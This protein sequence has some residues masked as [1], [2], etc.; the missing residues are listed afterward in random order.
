MCGI[1]GEFNF[2]GEAINRDAF[3]ARRD[4]LAHRG[5]DAAKSWFS[6][7]G[8]L[9]LGQRRLSIIDLDPR[10]N[11]PMTNEDNTVHVVVNGE[12]Y[13]F[14]VLK[15]ELESMGHLFSTTSDSEVVV[16]GWEEWGKE[17]P[18]RLEGMFALAV[19][20]K[21][22][23]FLCR[24]RFGIKPLYYFLVP[25]K[26]I[27]SSE[28]KSIIS[29]PGFYRKIDSSSFLDFFV[30]RYIPSPKTI[31]QNVSKLP[32][33]FAAEIN[34]Q[35]HFSAWEYWKPVLSER[36]VSLD[37]AAAEALYLFEN[38]MKSHLMSDVPVGTFLSGGYDSSS[39]VVMQHRLNAL[40]ITFSMG[41]EGWNKSEHLFA[42]IVA[43]R[44]NTKHYSEIVKNNDLEIIDEL[45]FYYD[46]PN[47]DISTLPT[48]MVSRLASSKVK[49]VLSGEGA[50]EIFAGYSWHHLL[51]DEFIRKTRGEKIT[52]LH[53]Y[54]QAMAMGLFDREKLQELAG[55]EISTFI[56]DDPFW[57]YKQ[58]FKLDVHPLKACQFLDI[59]TFMAELVLQKVDRA[60]MAHSLEARV[61]FL[62]RKLVEFMLSLHPDAY[63]SLGVQ[64]P[65]LKK[66]LAQYLPPEIL[67]R[68]KHGFKGPDRFYQ[69]DQWYRQKLSKSKLVKN[70][71]VKK[72][73][74]DRAL[75]QGD[76]WRL[77]KVV[78]M[79]EWFEKWG[80]Q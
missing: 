54:A 25:G 33:A 58:H 73:F 47:G 16:H 13:N 1:I 49:V 46:E 61:P 59:K 39:M 12:I 42:E 80:P 76:Y 24:D 27:F 56:P 15:K 51:M 78:V 74:V 64:K 67:N 9:A 44:L 45:S 75:Q 3:D 4:L 31:W 22:G 34:S 62:D 65:I 11:Q 48:F 79:G 63:Y 53:S 41:F 50:D 20:H 68:K 36:K 21:D 7:I 2:N 57:F 5:P 60:S 70:G 29:H 19:A 10:A 32:P 23:I 69:N 43:K 77:W 26:L 8:N 52:G 35:G 38:S 6:D 71:L 55:D 30:Y 28:L 66:L 40:S 17:L 18:S 14:Q 72:Q 37:E